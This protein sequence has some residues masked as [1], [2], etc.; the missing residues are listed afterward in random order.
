MSSLSG[1]GGTSIRDQE[2]EAE[3]QYPTARLDDG[4]PKKKQQDIRIYK[5]MSGIAKSSS[6]IKQE[7]R[8]KPNEH[9]ML[10]LAK[11]TPRKITTPPHIHGMP[12]E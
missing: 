8:N 4:D 7:M 3:R 1:N 10:K 12:S 9:P 5:N 2:D 11:Y 6:E